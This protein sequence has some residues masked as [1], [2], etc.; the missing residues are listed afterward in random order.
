MCVC[1]HISEYLKAIT[2]SVDDV[3]C[4]Y[5]KGLDGRMSCAVLH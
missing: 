2:V 1:V 3:T 5:E 4:L